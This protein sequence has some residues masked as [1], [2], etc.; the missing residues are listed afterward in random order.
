MASKRSFLTGQLDLLWSSW[1]RLRWVSGAGYSCLTLPPGSHQWTLPLPPF[2]HTGTASA[3]KGEEPIPSTSLR[4]W[5]SLQSQLQNQP[6]PSVTHWQL[7]CEGLNVRGTKARGAGCLGQ[8][9]RLHTPG[10]CRSV[11]AP[12]CKFTW[13]RWVWWHQTLRKPTQHQT[14]LGTGWEAGE[15]G[16]PLKTSTTDQ[17]RQANYTQGLL[18]GGL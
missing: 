6:P 9:P 18:L 16:M 11:R 8:E 7:P 10:R 12:G 5:R 1:G 15:T 13:R 14:R 2:F 3:G 17:F 4:L